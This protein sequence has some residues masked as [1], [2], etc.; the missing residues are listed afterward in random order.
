MTC[1]FFQARGH[2][3]IAEDAATLSGYTHCIGH[4]IGMDVHEAPVFSAGAHNT[5]RLQPGHVFTFEPGLYYPDENV[6]CRLEDILWVAPDGTI[7]TLTDY[8]YDLI[9]PMG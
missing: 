7:E 5:T 2:R 1:D 6:A 4:G 8:P 9:V 3:T